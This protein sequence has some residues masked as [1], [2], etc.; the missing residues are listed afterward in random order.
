MNSAVTTWTVSLE[1]DDG[2]CI[3]QSDRQT[4]DTCG[5]D[6]RFMSSRTEGTANNLSSSFSVVSIIQTLDG[7]V[8]K[9][10]EGTV[11]IGTDNICITGK[12]VCI[13]TNI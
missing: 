1:G 11:T 9:C 4:P 3:Y 2:E 12:F 13:A 6:D 5:P 7:T 10:L 8:I